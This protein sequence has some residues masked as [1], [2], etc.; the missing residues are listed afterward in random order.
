[1][2]LS[3]TRHPARS[4]DPG[5]QRATFILRLQREPHGPD[6]A[7]W[8]GT[9]EHVQSGERRAVQDAEHAAAVVTG[10]LRTLDESAD[11]GAAGSSRRGTPY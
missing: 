10:W 9:I 4:D 2:P 5:A 6:R 8:R 11:A 3:P 1:M 7:V